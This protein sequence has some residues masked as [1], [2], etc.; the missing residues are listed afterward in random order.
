[1]FN[2]EQ[3]MNPKEALERFCKN[4][5]GDARNGK[6]DPVIGMSSRSSRF[7]KYDDE[8]YFEE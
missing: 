2:P 5:V 7:S 1:M 8:E 3:Q 6:L 4:L